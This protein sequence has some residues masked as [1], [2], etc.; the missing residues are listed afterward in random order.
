MVVY[1][2]IDR[3]RNCR[4]RTQ[5]GSHSIPHLSRQV[6]IFIMSVLEQI[7][8][9]DVTNLILSKSADEYCDN[10]FKLMSALSNNKS[11]QSIRLEGDFLDDL[12]SI[13]R[14]EVLESI[15]PIPTLMTVH[16]G[17]SFLLASDIA[18]VLGGT[19]DL[20]ELNLEQLVLQGIKVDFDLLESNLHAHSSLKLNFFRMDE[21]CTAISDSSLENLNESAKKMSTISSPVAKRETAQTA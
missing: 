3:E 17:Y 7:E 19:P 14:G 1:G 13:K 2:D 15:I 11:I 21:C 9:N 6:I 18:K 5:S 8:G 4:I 12:S 16:L 10:I 20:L